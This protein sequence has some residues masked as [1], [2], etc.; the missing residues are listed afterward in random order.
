LARALRA[1][2]Y[3]KKQQWQTALTAY[4]VAVWCLFLAFWAA[5][6]FHRDMKREEVIRKLN[7]EIQ[8]SKA[9]DR[10]N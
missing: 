5:I 7:V 6:Q 2:D 9:Q 3:G 4:Q 8:A 1:L 10:A